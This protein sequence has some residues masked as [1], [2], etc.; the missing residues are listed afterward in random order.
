[1]HAQIQKVS[2]LS[3]IERRETCTE[4]DRREVD[5]CMH[6]YDKNGSGN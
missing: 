3:E 4:R 2:V 1:M 5:S 6:N